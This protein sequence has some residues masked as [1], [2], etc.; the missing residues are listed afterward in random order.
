MPRRLAPV[1]GVAVAVIAALALSGPARSQAP[2]D[3]KIPHGGYTA[4]THRCETCHTVHDAPGD[5]A[6]LSAA[7][8]RE[9]CY[10]CHDGS[11]TATDVKSQFGTEASP[12]TSSHPVGSDALLCS[13]CH[14]GHRSPDD[15]TALLRVKVDG[16]YRYSPPASLGTPIGDDFCYACHGSGSTLPAPDGDHS[17][18]ETSAHGTSAAMPP[19]KS[20]SQIECLACH[21]P[22]GS[23]Q[24]GLTTN[25][26][27]QEELCYSC[28]TAA[29]PNTSGGPAPIAPSDPF[30]AF[31]GTPN[32]YDQDA[33]GPSAGIRLFHHPVSNVDQ[34][35]G[36][37]QVEC[38]SC[39][40][41]HLADQSDGPGTSKL[42]NP[43]N[44]FQKY[45]VTWTAGSYGQRGNINGF[46]ATCHVS[47]DTTK[48]LTAT[49]DGSVPYTVWMVDDTGPMYDSASNPA[50]ASHAHD[51]FDY[52]YWSSSDR[53]HGPNGA[54]LACT[55]CHDFHGSSNA[56]MLKETVIS[57]GPDTAP[58]TTNTVTG[59]QGVSSVAGDALKIQS[60]CNTCHTGTHQSG[61]ECT[62]CHYHGDT[63]A[64][65]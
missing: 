16:H 21:E 35:G 27:N 45:P 34:A 49:P 60:F 18:F 22:H 6:I 17:A 52:S 32:D 62:S 65:W 54:N 5:T 33:T 31:N 51:N 3:V 57:V 24:P 1:A 14:T 9:L 19:P 38:I 25:G 41:P 58:G 61:R 46:C 37:R 56:Y 42:V 47:P 13:D 26:L 15:D 63:S 50:K 29:D 12:K 43:A 59:W 23:D 53:S 48:P 44:V 7:N 30:D 28:H 10:S 39:H 36:T 64:K 2:A 40:G 11:T 8:E 4:S 55:A 20:G